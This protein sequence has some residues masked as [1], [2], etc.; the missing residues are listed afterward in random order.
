MLIVAIHHYVHQILHLS[1]S[2]F[3]VMPKKS[4]VVDNFLFCSHS[5]SYDD[6]SILAREREIK[7][8]RESVRK[9]RSTIFE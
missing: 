8:E 4:S 6:F 1:V 3:E 7:T 9:E 5:V 2:L